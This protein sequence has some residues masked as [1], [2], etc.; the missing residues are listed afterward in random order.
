MLSL[1]PSGEWV[2]NKPE[3]SFCGKAAN[4]V[5]CLIAGPGVSIC[6]ECVSLCVSVLS[7][8]GVELPPPYPELT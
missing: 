6:E 4:Q 7:D 5:K 1:A 2:P 8:K 3:C